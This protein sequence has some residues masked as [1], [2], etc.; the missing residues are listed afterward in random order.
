MISQEPQGI[1]GKKPAQYSFY[2]V[3]VFW[4]E[5]KN[6]LTLN[7]LTLRTHP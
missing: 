3:R 6:V 7:I 2:N 5:K 1:S 4:E